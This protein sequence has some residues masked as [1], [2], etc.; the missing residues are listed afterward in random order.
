LS[1]IIT[2]LIFFDTT[3]KVETIILYA[4]SPLRR[5]KGS[6]SDGYGVTLSGRRIERL[7]SGELFRVG[8]RSVSQEQRGLR[9]RLSDDRNAQ[10]LFKGLLGKC[11]D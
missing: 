9:E 3:S 1:A 11:N 8:D 6:L 7:E 5:L 4:A 10:N 2:Y